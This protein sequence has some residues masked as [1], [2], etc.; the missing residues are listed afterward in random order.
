MDV[1]RIGSFTR[2]VL[3]EVARTTGGL[4][5]A[6]LE[7]REVAVESSPAQFASLRDGEFDAIFT[8]PDNVLAYRFLPANPLGEVLDVEIVAGLD[9]GPGRAS[10]HV[11]RWRR[12]LICAAGAWESTC[13]TRGSRSWRTHCLRN[14]ASRGTTTRS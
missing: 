5:Q 10:V 3:L 2:S 4:T 7:V 11:P 8:S 14:W 13:R 1:L 9:R 12:R 6:N